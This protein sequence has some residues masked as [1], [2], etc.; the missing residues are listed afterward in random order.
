MKGPLFLAPCLGLL[1]ASVSHAQQRPLTGQMLAQP[2]R[3]AAP[4]PAAAPDPAPAPATQRTTAQAVAPTPPAATSVASAP[5]PPPPPPR[6]TPLPASPPPL[7]H[8]HG[9]IGSTTRGLLQL[10]ASGRHAGPSLPILGD[11][12][13]RSHQR[14]LQSFEYPIPEFFENRVKDEAAN[15][16]G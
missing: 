7:A 14:Y 2:A 12:A 1:L 9:G 5:A 16:G 10:Q 4:A 13:R 15:G 6:P 3:P 11:Q 8:P